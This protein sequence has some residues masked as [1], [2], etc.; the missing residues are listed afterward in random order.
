MAEEQKKQT[1]K[2]RNY[3]A[4]FNFYDVKGEAVERKN[5]F[6]PKCG[7]GAFLAI[8]KD[9]LSCGG[10]SYTEKTAVSPQPSAVS[11]EKKAEP[12]AET[13]TTE[14]PKKEEPKEE[15][16]EKPTTDN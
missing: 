2:K 5:K 7:P 9:R 4:K 12:S 6:C 16:N 11:V 15:K 3:K 10:C 1:G 14:T 13:P 8:H